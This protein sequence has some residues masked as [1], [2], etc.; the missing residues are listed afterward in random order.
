MPI[1]RVNGKK[2]DIPKDKVSK[3]ESVYPDATVDIYD[4][5]SG[6]GYEIP[7]SKVGRFKNRFPKWSYEKGAVASYTDVTDVSEAGEVGSSVEQQ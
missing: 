5:A 6:K 7:V 3:F 2:Y 1:Y 4:N